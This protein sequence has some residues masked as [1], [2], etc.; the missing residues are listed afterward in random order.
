MGH[1][2]SLTGTDHLDIN[3][4]IVPTRLEAQRGRVWPVLGG[5]PL[6]QAEEVTA[7]SQAGQFHICRSHRREGSANLLAGAGELGVGATLGLGWGDLLHG[8]VVIAVRAGFR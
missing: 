7:A 4:F 8:A 3:V 2:K 6:C 1:A 5:C